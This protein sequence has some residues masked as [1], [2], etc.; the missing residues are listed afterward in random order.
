MTA[1][2]TLRLLATAAAALAGLWFLLPTAAGGSTTYLATHGVSMQPRFS[3]GD[4]AVLRPAD[5]YRVGDVIAYQSSTLGTVVMHRIVQTDGDRYVTEGDNNSWL[6]PDHPGADDVLGRL[7]F[8]V[9]S[10]G[11]VLGLLRS[12]TGIALELL[13]TAGLSM[14]GTRRRHGRHRNRRAAAAPRVFAPAV[15]L[16]A[17]QAAPVLGALTLLACLGETVLLLLPATQTHVAQATVTQTGR[18]DY[19]A[20]AARG[21]TYPTG[22]VTTGDPVYLRLVDGL[23]VS[24][25][26]TVEGRGLSDLTGTVHLD[27]ALA[28]AD[29]WRAELP[30]GAPA[31]PD[32][33][34][35]AAAV[36]LD[37]AAAAALLR[38]HAAEVGS[39][40]TA[41]SLTVTPV[42]E[43]AGTVAGR[44]WSAGPVPGVSFGLDAN[45]LQL[46]GGSSALAPVVPAIVHVPQTGPRSLGAA[47]GT[48]P[49]RVARLAVAL[50]LAVVA[51]GWLVATRLARPGSAGAELLPRFTGRVVAVSAITPAGAVIDVRDAAAL[52]RVAERLDLPVLHQR[53]PGGHTFAVQD[54]DTTYR[55]VVLAPAPDVP[56]RPPLLQPA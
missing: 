56:T 25:T 53:G 13:G 39:S 29:G 7:W 10:G 42:V 46:T 35:V 6:D 18:F 43:L 19:S 38:Q 49:L 2:R 47:W 37:P 36:R 3:T 27:V 48:V 1:T 30:S 17:R 52:R 33:G 40:G 31:A 12:P 41:A 22:T 54:S 24:F 5:G 26:D 14:L 32:G 11:A 23:T 8:R 20:T 55:L 44:S 4:L 21:A 51:L 45:T 50:L 16:P 15:R 9:P 28:T 34:R